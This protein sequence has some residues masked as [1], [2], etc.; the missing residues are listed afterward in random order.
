VPSS[1]WT[2]GD[3][4]DQQGRRIVITGGNSGIGLAAARV[5]AGAG[6]LVII[7]VRDQAKGQRAASEIGDDTEVRALDLADLN[8]VRAFAAETIEP[9]DVLINNAGVMAPPL[10]RTVQGFETQFGSTTSATLR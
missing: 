6:A 4:A 9:I 3:L 5:L 7:A 8:S 2:A 1:S 10:S